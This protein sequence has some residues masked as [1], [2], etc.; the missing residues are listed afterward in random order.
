MNYSHAIFHDNI[1][2]IIVIIIEAPAFDCFVINLKIK[3]EIII[4]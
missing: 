1:N 3:C 2:V 4:R